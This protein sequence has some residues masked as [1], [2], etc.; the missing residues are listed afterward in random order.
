MKRSK[1]YTC[2][3]AAYCMAAGLALGSGVFFALPPMEAAASPEFAYPPEKWAALRDN[4]MEYGE[5][6]DLVHEYNVTVINNRL[7]YDEYRGKSHDDL[8]NAYQ[9]LAD[10]MYQASDDLLDSV[11]EDDPGYGSAA[12]QAALSR[13]QAEQNQDLADAQNEDGAI[14]KLEYERD[15]AQLVQQAQ[16]K[17]I[18]YWQKEEARPSLEAAYALAQAQYEAAAVRA[19]AGM[20]SQ[21]ELLAAQEKAESAKGA[22][23]TN[24]KEQDSLRRELCVMTGWAHDASPDIQP[25]PI[26]GE[27]ELNAVCPEEDTNRAVQMNFVQRA[28]EGRLKYTSTAGN[29]REVMEKKVAA[30]A[31]K[32]KA[33]VAAKY[34]LLC[35][36]RENYEQ[37]AREYKL[38]ESQ[39]EAAELRQGL[40]MISANQ[41]EEQRAG[42]VQKQAAARQAGL[43][44]RQALEDY[45]WTVNGLAQAE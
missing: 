22:L 38:A 27:E 23:R 5:L 30:G 39:A 12:A 19:G 34:Q 14:K 35:Q 8:K 9:D 18:S 15:E 17:M 7:E 2:R 11:N 28:N 25:V 42:L 1:K 13:V 10:T 31:G 26:P 4:V 3:M 44:L 41:Y 37:A 40:G 36:A 29:Q 33:D 24:E 32:I 16:T 45:R 6:A 43:S 21:A 20:L